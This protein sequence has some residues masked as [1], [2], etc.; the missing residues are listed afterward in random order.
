MCKLTFKLANV[1][2]KC[3][4]V[5]SV[6]VEVLQLFLNTKMQKNFTNISA[7]VKQVLFSSLTHSPQR[8]RLL[9]KAEHF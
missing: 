3:C 9:T 1:K 6:F 7:A 4:L 5:T 8:L 2:K